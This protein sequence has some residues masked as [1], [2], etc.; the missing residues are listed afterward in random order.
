MADVL[1][2]GTVI[3]PCM[4]KDKAAEWAQ[5]LYGLKA[6]DM[7]EFNSYDDRNYY[8][9]VD[10][11][12][13]VDN[14]HILKE[15]ICSDGYV[16]KITNTLDSKDP[17][18]SEAQN[19]LILHMAIAKF[20]V[21]VPMKDKNGQLMSFQE[22]KVETK[23]DDWTSNNDEA[24]KTRINKHIVRLL[25]FIPGKILYDIDPWIPRHF[26][27]TGVFVAK[28]D[29]SLKDF[30][31]EAYE[32][33]NSIWFLPSIPQV[34]QFLGAVQDQVHRNMCKDIMETFTTQVLDKHH[35][36]LQS[37]I[38]H[39]DFNEQN[40]LVRPRSSEQPNDYEVFSV[41]DFG[42]SQKNPLVYELGITIMYMMTKCSV[43]DPNEAGGHVLAGYETV[44]PLP[45]LE[46]EVLRMCVAARYAQS[47]V[48]GAYSHQQDP[49]NDYLLVTAATGWK[50]LT[51]F[52][53][54]PKAD[55]YQKWDEI[56]K[57]YRP[58]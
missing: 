16:L 4:D 45:E 13:L 14:E 27:E 23:G 26:Y 31:H 19:G 35:A 18:F 47:L 1:E 53:N 40:I 56:K 30:Y 51:R 48:M 46:M 12:A 44:R 36:S 2:P 24:S 28:M 42:D 37:G 33:R 21:P 50:N 9:K 34:K 3:K 6:I 25:K 5:S 32:S 49:T 29:S 43:I 55:L 38:I 54:L 20:A 8:F 11:V 41:I 22:L 15:D 7:K 39:G 17:A 57:S 58:Q 52:W 10:P